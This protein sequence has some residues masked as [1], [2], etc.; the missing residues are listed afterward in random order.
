LKVC[1]LS[2]DTNRR[3]VPNPKQ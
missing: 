2:R 1:I 3:R